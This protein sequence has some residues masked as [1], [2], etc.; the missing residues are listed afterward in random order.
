MSSFFVNNYLLRNKIKHLHNI[1]DANLGMLRNK[2]QHILNPHRP[3]KIRQ[4]AS[5]DMSCLTYIA[6]FDTHFALHQR[7]YFELFLFII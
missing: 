3:F 1:S 7:S 6:L 5:M 4:G 2:L